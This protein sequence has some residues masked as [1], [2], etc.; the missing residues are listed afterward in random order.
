GEANTRKAIGDVQRFRDDNDAAL[1]SYEQALGL[2]RDVGDRLGEANT[3]AAQGQLFLIDNPERADAM[4]EQA[5]ADFQQI[6]DSY[7]I[8]AQIGNYGLA[9]LRLQ[10]AERAQPYLTRAA[11]LFDQIG[12]DDYAARHRQSAAAIPALRYWASGNDFYKEKKYDNAIAEFRRSLDLL[13]NTEAW[14]GLGNALESLERFDE[15]IEAYSRAIELDSD[16]AYLYRNRANVLLN[17]NRLAD[18][19]HDIARAVE[20]EPDS[21]YTHARQA[22][23]ALRRGEFAEAV[24]HYEYTVAHDENVDW[25]FGLALAKFG[26]GDLAGAKAISAEANAQA[27][28]D[29]KK[30]IRKWFERVA[31]TRPELA[32]AVRALL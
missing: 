25:K 3:L 10:Q 7:S 31:K 2:F 11:E 30:E 23:L 1:T 13:P 8:A 29:E 18:A 20:L 26:A 21:A 4:L 6:G 16:A 28:E 9:L 12:L 32:D 24:S 22:E 14:N 17:L 27:D 19:E 5:I 15:A